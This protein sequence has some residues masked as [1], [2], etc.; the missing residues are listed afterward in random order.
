MPHASGQDEPDPIWW[1]PRH[2][3][4]RCRRRGCPGE[5]DGSSQTSSRPRRW[6]WY[7]AVGKSI[8]EIAKDLD[9]TETALREWV[10]KA[11]GQQPRKEG[12]LSEDERAKLR[13]LEEE[14]RVLKME[15]DFLKKAAGFFA[16]ETK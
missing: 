5:P 9:L 6:T 12:P 3:A 7:A 16:K 11:D 10:K 8:G 15:R 4:N 2:S 13:R 1:T 14:N